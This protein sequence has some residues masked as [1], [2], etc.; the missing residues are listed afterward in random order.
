MLMTLHE[1]AAVNE[2]LGVALRLEGSERVT[3]RPAPLTQ[4]ELFQNR[5]NQPANQI[6]II[7]TLLLA[8]LLETTYG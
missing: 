2:R 5:N 3:I 7:F 6:V 1:S 8:C 4:C